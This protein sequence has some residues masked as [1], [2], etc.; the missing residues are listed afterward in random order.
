MI[1]QADTFAVQ[2]AV[3]EEKEGRVRFFGIE[4]QVL[5][6]VY[7][8]VPVDDKVEMLAMYRQIVFVARGHDSSCRNA[9]HSA[10]A[11]FRVGGK[12]DG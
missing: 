5:F 7:G 9:V 3:P 8:M 11:S 4:I 2:P 1:Q 6:E 10:A 12:P